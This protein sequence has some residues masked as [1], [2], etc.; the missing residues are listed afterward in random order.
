[1]NL[2][3]VS[4]CFWI[5]LFIASVSL[6][7]IAASPVFVVDDWLEIS[8]GNIIRDGAVANSSKRDKSF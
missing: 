6:P 5:N 7:S 3:F 2:P 4:F 1:M 8:V